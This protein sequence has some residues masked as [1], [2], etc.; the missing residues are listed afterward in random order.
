MSKTVVIRHRGAVSTSQRGVLVSTPTDL[1]RT[2]SGQRVR[3][4]G[5]DWCLGGLRPCSAV[6]GADAAS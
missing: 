1:S 4:C 6:W 5:Q 2:V 3:G